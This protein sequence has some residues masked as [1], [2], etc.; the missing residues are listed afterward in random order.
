MMYVGY[1]LVI[2]RVD[3][4]PPFLYKREG[5]NPFIAVETI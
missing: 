4:W 5:P 3:I 2:P 1:M